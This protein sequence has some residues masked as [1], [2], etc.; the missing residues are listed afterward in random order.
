MVTTKGTVSKASKSLGGKKSKKGKNARTASKAKFNNGAKSTTKKNNKGL[1]GKTIAKQ[2]TATVEVAKAVKA[3][4]DATKALAENITPSSG[5]SAIA[6]ALKSYV[7]KETSKPKK[8]QNIRRK[9]VVTDDMKSTFS[10][11]YKK[12]STKT[13][14]TTKRKTT[15]TRKPRTNFNT[16]GNVN[17]IRGPKTKSG[18]N[19]FI[20]HDWSSGEPR[21]FQY[22][23]SKI[24]SH[25]EK[26]ASSMSSE[27]KAGLGL[28]QL[29]NYD[30][31]A[32]Y[33]NQVSAQIILNW[34]RARKEITKGPR[35]TTQTSIKKYATSSTTK[36]STSKAKPASKP[37][38]TKQTSITSYFTNSTTKK[39]TSKAKPASK[40]RKT[41]QTTIRT[42]AKRVSKTGKPL[43]RPKGSKNKAGHKAG[44]P[45]GSGK[46]K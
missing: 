30:L 24:K 17:I 3:N 9:N 29:F 46:K 21:Q 14:S 34:A 35:R 27:Q 8:K 23:K 15:T 40:P 6:K 18:K 16:R 19:I 36:K 10:G 26:I 32:I 28:F 11:A 7:D 44:R 1:N 20:L 5:G 25:V 31:S 2:A 13:K 39:S 33:P 4:A 45:K 37:R 43:G 41:T 42:Y 22:T 12:A 38:K